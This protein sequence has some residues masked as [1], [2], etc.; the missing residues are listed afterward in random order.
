MMHSVTEATLKGAM[1]LF[2][3]GILRILSAML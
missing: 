2:N 1:L 3:Y